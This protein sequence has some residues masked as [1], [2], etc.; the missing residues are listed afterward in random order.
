[1]NNYCMQLIFRHAVYC[2]GCDLV[3]LQGSHPILWTSWTLINREEIPQIDNVHTVF[4]VDA[5]YL[6]Y[7]QSALHFMMS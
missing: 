3:S 2:F 1:M 5:T 7:L 4:F 6:P